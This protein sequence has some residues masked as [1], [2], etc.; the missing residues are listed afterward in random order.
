MSW[1]MVGSAVASA[2]IQS[3]AQNDASDRQAGIADQM[4]AYNM[5]KSAAALDATNK[6]LG[7]IAPAQRTNDIA[8]AE[9]TTA[10]RLNSGL[11]DV[12]AFENK[13][14]FG[15]KVNKAYTDSVEAGAASNADRMKKLIGNLSVIGAPGQVSLKNAGTYDA[16]AANVGSNMDAIN[17]VDPYYRAAINTVRPDPLLTFVAQAVQGAGMAKGMGAFGPKIAPGGAP[18]S[19]GTP[20]T[21]VFA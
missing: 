5:P 3:K 10:G 1:W 4:R 8:A 16:S 6:Y 18:T 13:N 12:Q 19:A 21:S 9:A 11:A 7:A 14:N 20:N 17:K 2:L 15:G